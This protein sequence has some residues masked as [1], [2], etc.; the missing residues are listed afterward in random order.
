MISSSAQ[1]LIKNTPTH[2]SCIY[3]VT[4]QQTWIFY[5][6][7]LHQQEKNMKGVG[8]PKWSIF[9]RKKKTVLLSK[10]KTIIIIIVVDT[11]WNSIEIKY[12]LHITWITVNTHQAP[13]AIKN[14]CWQVWNSITRYGLVQLSNHKDCVVVI[15]IFNLSFPVVFWQN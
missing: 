1:N 6:V 4:H 7:L 5:L 11:T 14:L 3:L 10:I 9:V 2:R 12:N 15:Y 8:H 13:N